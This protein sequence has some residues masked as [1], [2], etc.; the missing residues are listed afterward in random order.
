M[1]KGDDI[2]I[3]L[4]EGSMVDY[5]EGRDVANG[6]RLLTRILHQNSVSEAN[7]GFLGGDWGYG[8]NYEND[9]F[10]MHSF[11]WCEEAECP[12]CGGC[13]CPESAFHYF[14][15]AQEVSFDEWIKFYED[16]VYCGLSLHD[17]YAKFGYDEIE[18]HSNEADL[19]RGQRHDPVCDFCLGKGIFKK[20]QPDPYALG[21][22]HFWHKK[23]GL[24]VWWYKYIG[25]G[26]KVYNPKNVEWKKVLQ[27][28]IDSLHV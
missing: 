27:E 9:V 7:R 24:K 26:E 12:W 22:P 6:L 10:M 17:A 19:H 21:A 14:V 20:Y 25:R 18:K 1:F 23:S 28:C 5:E 3:I 4:P 2:Q 11:C 13:T 16:Y 8:T 15:D